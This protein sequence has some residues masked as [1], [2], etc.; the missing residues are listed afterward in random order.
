MSKEKTTK[1]QLAALEELIAWF[2]SDDF[3]LEEA[4]AKFK[5][6]EALAGDIRQKLTELGNDITVLNKKFDDDAA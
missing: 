2:E 3:S 5:E 1:E 4:Q 6:A